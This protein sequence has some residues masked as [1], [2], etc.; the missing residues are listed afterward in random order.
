VVNSAWPNVDAADAALAGMARLPAPAEV[1]SII[2]SAFQADLRVKLADLTSQELAEDERAYRELTPELRDR[3][4]TCTRLLGVE[5][6]NLVSLAAN[7]GVTLGL[8]L[9]NL[10]DSLGPVFSPDYGNGTG[11]IA[12]AP[13]FGQ[14]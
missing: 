3:L 6:V 9:D 12:G 2:A 14:P 10:R 13:V 8:L 4:D 7:L 5:P 11:V 1:Q